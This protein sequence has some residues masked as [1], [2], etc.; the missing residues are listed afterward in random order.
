[1]QSVAGSTSFNDVVNFDLFIFNP[2]IILGGLALAFGLN[3]ASVARLRFQDGSLVGTIKFQGKFLNLGL[4]TFVGL[5]LGIIFVYLLAE[6]F[7]VFA[8]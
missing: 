3:L 5:L 4:L 1:M 8:G 6:N 7:Q 2:I